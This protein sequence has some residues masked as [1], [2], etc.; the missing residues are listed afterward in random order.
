L[1]VSG[2]VAVGLL[3]RLALVAYVAPFPDRTIQAD[4]IGYDRLAINLVAGNGFSSKD[5][6][7]FTLDNLRTP[8]YPLT[9][10]AMYALFGHRPDLVL[11]LQAFM[12][13]FTIL[14]TYWLGALVAGPRA[15]AMAAALLA[16]S[17]LSISYAAVLWSDTEY[18]LVFVVSMLL[19]VLMFAEV[20]LKW[21]VLNGLAAG[22]AV[23][24]HP[25]SLYL[26]YLLAILLVGV[27]LW[28]RRQSVGPIATGNRVSLS[29]KD[30][31]SEVETPRPGVSTVLRQVGAYLLVFNLA[32]VPWRLRNLAAFRVPNISSAAGIN[33]LQYGAALTE[34]AQTGESQWPITERYEADVKAMSFRPLTE[35]EFAELAF[36]LGLQKISRS[37]LVYARVHLVGMARIFAPGTLTINTL[38][39]GQE[40]FDIGQ[41]YALATS[42]RF[43]QLG[44]FFNGLLGYAKLVIGLIA[45][46]ALSLSAIY[47]LCVWAVLQ[48]GRDA[49]PGRL[50]GPWLLAAVLF[51]LAAVAGPAGAPRFRVAMM[52]LLG[53]LAACGAA[54]MI[55]ALSQVRARLAA[56]RGVVAAD[57]LTTQSAQPLAAR[58]DERA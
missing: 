18:T 19:T 57:R 17:P 54:A 29:H 14:L 46:E 52:P 28:Q 37:P 30:A 1:A 40:E 13:A 58:R 15:G 2:I 33:M 9:V 34:A 47:L 22:S 24:V 26:P 6:P 5:T 43:D 49:P 51:Y 41:I 36:R 21:A 8:G 39:T 55:L 7:P 32:L 12:G 11:W 4:A 56:R 27:A 50:Y 25:R 53:V 31:P 16:V 20:G 23:L 3:L 45:F 38:I 48:R 42:G 10:A 44:R 35:A